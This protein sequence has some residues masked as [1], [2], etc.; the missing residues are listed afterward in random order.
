MH[1]AFYPTSGE[2]VRCEKHVK[3]F[4][5]V[6]SDG[7]IPHVASTGEVAFTLMGKGFP[8][9]FIT[10]IYVWRGRKAAKTWYYSPVL[11]ER[12]SQSSHIGSLKVDAHLRGRS[13]SPFAW[14]ARHGPIRRYTLWQSG[15]V[16]WDQCAVFLLSPSGPDAKI[17]SPMREH[18]V[19]GNAR[20]HL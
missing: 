15:A 4:S 19:Q 10:L 6:A 3:V 1:L 16:V 17:E 7:Q 14:L 9:L 5:K 13:I 12:C 8:T 20:L 2:S 11:A 18:I